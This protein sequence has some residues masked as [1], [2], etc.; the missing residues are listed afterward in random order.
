MFDIGEA[1]KQDHAYFAAIDEEMADGGRE[2]L[3]YHLLYEVDLKQVNLRVVP[4]TD[5]LRDQQIESMNTEQS[6][7][8]DTLMNGVLPK[9]S[10]CNEPGLCLK[11]GLHARYVHHAQQQGAAFRSAQTKLGIFLNKQLGDGLKEARPRIGHDRPHCYQMPSLKDCREKFAAALGRSI[12]WGDVWEQ[13]DWLF[14]VW[15]IGPVEL[16]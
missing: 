11:E 15:N 8:M 2:A 12:D 7:W 4:K 3:L 14:E 16:S 5:A 1:H 13:D 6:W 10:R 9:P